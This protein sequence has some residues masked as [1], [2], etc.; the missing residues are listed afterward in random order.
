[1][2]KMIG[3]FVFLICIGI[4]IVNAQS[5][6]ITGTVTSAEDGIGMPGVS[7]VVKG[8]TVGAST[9]IDGKYTLQAKASDVL[10]FSFVGMIPQ[11]IKVGNQTTINVVLKT[12]S[13]GVD[14]VVVLGYTVKHKNEMTG[15]S[16][17][18]NAEKLENTP[19]VSV[20]Q[21]LQGRVAGLSISGTSGTPGA[22]QNIRI[23]GVNSI[24][25]GN[26][27]LYVVDGVPIV[28]SN[29]A[30][31]T[32][33]STLSPLAA[34]DPNNISSVTVLKDAS[35]VAAYG[36][37]GAN[38]VIIVT[39]KAGKAG[40][41]VFDF[42]A[43]YGFANDAVDGRDVLTAAQRDELRYEAIV[44]SGIAKDIAD[45]KKK[46]PSGW[47]GKTDANWGEV[48]KN[49]DAKQQQYSFSARGG[50]AKSAFYASLGYFKSE[51]TVIGADFRRT[52]GS[53]SYRR[54]LTDKLKFTTKTNA[55][56]SIQRG[57][58]EQ[59]AYFSGQRTAKYF[60]SPDNK[61]YNDDGTINTN[62]SGNVK[63]PLYI[64]KHNVERNSLTR[65]LNNSSILYRFTDKLKFESKLALDYYI[66]DYKQYQNRNYG[67]GKE[68]NGSG[69][70]SSTQNFNYVFQN[71]VSYRWEIDEDHRLDAK[72][73]M[74]Y[75]QNNS[76]QLTAAG[77]QFATDGITNLII[78]GKPTGANFLE[79]DWK[80]VSY[81]GLFNY[82]FRNKYLLDATIRREGSSRFGSG[83][84]FGTFWS[85][86]GAW[87]I[88]MEDFLMD[89]EII[90]SLKLRASYGK[91]G[92]SS[93]DINSYQPLLSYDANYEGLGAAYPS[94]YGNR[95]LTWEKAD[96][97][98]MGIDF[99]ILNNRISGEISYFHKKTYDL[100]QEVPLSRTSGHNIQARNLGEMKNTGF[101]FM[102][103]AD[104]IKSKDL[105]WSVG[106]NLATVK[107]EVTKLAKDLNNQ[108][109]EITNSRKRVAVGE[110]VYAWYMRKWAGVNP[111]N[112]LAQWYVKEGSDEITTNYNAAQ[113]QFVG[114]S[115]LPKFT[116]GINTHFDFKGFFLDADIY[117]AGGHKVFEEWARYLHQGGIYNFA[118]FNG[119]S[120][121]MNRWQKPGDR[122]DV[123]KVLWDTDRRRAEVSS[124]FLYDGDYARL[125][126]LTIGYTIPN[127]LTRQIGL[128]NVKVFFKGV[129]LL[130]WVK[131]DKLE[132]DPEVQASGYLE[133]NTPP[134]KSY[135][136]GINVKF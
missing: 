126:N 82:S 83:E 15:S 33:G 58:L 107:N 102:L 26:E 105:N 45:A 116:G 110:P 115:A 129:N 93:I 47:D 106:F 65:I 104:I 42:S 54:D 56:N 70:N 94:Q 6:Q 122:T 119:V 64:A 87:N 100:L 67:D 30:V 13:I 132:H 51:A 77:N 66:S 36:A 97:F 44:N 88:H 84:R 71:S 75:Q 131:D 133:L 31:S 121:L 90:N 85:V 49:K 95:A 24:T 40:K 79:N 135:S 21:M 5:K 22:V 39:T 17:Q 91:T 113:R 23:R 9:D 41:T 11:E 78:A 72:V 73:L 124:R 114:G 55:S 46:L 60:S 96:V 48:I 59:S 43:V 28:N 109:I 89:N 57:L 34:L 80:N 61:P 127:S 112:G 62:L 128:S 25:A 68:T 63:N 37:R 12:E 136:F 130:T 18:V 14:E 3:L 16:V 32:S 4:Q 7:V 108:D 134:V 92:N 1:M 118:V 74:E 99:S 76:K 120:E 38:G 69:Y 81:L 50:N 2:K 53:F 103:N 20:D 35:A 111:D 8:T 27:P 29:V 125:K 52:S 117:F 10:I 19:V 98:D 101:E 123:P 86:G